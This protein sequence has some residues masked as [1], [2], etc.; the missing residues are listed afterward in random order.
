MFADRGTY[1]A[2]WK[3]FIL[4]IFLEFDLNDSTFPCYLLLSAWPTKGSI[5]ETFANNSDMAAHLSGVFTLQ[6]G[7]QLNC[8]P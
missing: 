7:D 1:W 3:Q 8:A 2:F 5:C 4:K 6:H